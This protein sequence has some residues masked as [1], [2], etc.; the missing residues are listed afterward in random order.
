MLCAAGLLHRARKLKAAALEAEKELRLI[1]PILMSLSAAAAVSQS[2]SVG[3]VSGTGNTVNA[4]NT[5][6]HTI[7]DAEKKSLLDKF[8]IPLAIAAATA[9]IQKLV[10]GK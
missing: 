3:S 10:G 5:V 7:H 1:A 9:L 8:W 6:N 2:A 4:T